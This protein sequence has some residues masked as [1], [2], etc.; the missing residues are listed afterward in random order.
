VSETN[1]RAAALSPDEVTAVVVTVTLLA[2]ARRTTVDHVV[3]VTPAWRFSGR[4]FDV[5]ARR[6]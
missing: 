4:H 2:S 6:R 1:P 5:S 3:D